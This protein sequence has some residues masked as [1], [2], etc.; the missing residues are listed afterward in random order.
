M[1]IILTVE[2]RFLFIH[3]SLC[4]RNTGGDH[5]FTLLVLDNINGVT[6]ILIVANSIRYDEKR[7]TDVKFFIYR[8]TTYNDD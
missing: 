2:K 3:N 7:R 4:G 6:I 5:T 1:L 8:K